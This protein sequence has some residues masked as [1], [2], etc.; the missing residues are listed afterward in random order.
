MKTLIT[1]IAVA[2]GLLG[3][4]AG[5]AKIALIPEEV[6]FLSRFGFTTNLIFTFGAIQLVGGALMMS[7]RTRLYG[8]LVTAIAFAV[9]TAL[10]LVAGNTAIAGLSL[11]PIMLAGLVAYQSRTIKSPS[12][13]RKKGS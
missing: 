10:L 11:A 1:V 6:A 2:I 13:R 8:S 3:I 12:V 4:A 5:A 7:R 9:S